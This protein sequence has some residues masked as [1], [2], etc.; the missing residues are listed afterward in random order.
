MRNE[1]EGFDSS[2]I[3]HPSSLIPLL[4]QVVEW[5]TRDAQNVVPFW[6]VGVRLS[7]WSLRS[8]L[9]VG[10][11]HGLISR[12]TRV[13]IPPPQLDGRVRKVVKRPGREPGEGLWVRFPPRLHKDEG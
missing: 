12:F 10:R 2:L 4:G 5:Q 7:P 6:G 8:G 1:E 3:P 13:R 11:Q 9:E